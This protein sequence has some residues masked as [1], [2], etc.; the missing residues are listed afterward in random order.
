MFVVTGIHNMLTHT[1]RGK[2]SS[3]G[4]QWDSHVSIRAMACTSEG[5]RLDWPTTG[6]ASPGSTVQKPESSPTAELTL[7]S[8]S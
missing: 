1:W 6:R 5:F 3:A 4:L 8:S 7:A 2:V